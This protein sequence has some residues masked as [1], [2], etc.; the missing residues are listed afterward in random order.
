MHGP[1]R[2]GPPRHELSNPAGRR[3][4]RE[5]SGRSWSAAWGS[6]T[7]PF[8]PRSGCTAWTVSPSAAATESSP[9]I[10]QTAQLGECAGD[11]A[12]VGV[13]DEV[14]EKWQRRTLKR[15]EYLLCGWVITPIICSRRTVE[16][17]P[18]RRTSG[19]AM[20]GPVQ[21]RTCSPWTLINVGVQGGWRRVPPGASDSRRRY[22]AVERRAFPR[23]HVLQSRREIGM[24]RSTRRKLEPTFEGDP[25]VFSLHND[26]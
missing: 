1:H 21:A 11:R 25:F 24:F 12:P 26:Q 2:S 7:S 3:G 18:S 13:L 15:S 6:R 20:P 17:G 8:G 9:L 10:R 4:D 19:I 14:A 5:A 16:R 23:T 22:S